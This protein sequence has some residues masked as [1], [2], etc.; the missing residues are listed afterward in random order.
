MAGYKQRCEV[1]GVATPEVAV[2]DNCCHVAT[3][4]SMHLPETPV[5]LDVYHF[6][7]RYAGRNIL[8]WMIS[9]LIWPGRYLAAVLNG[10]KNPHRSAIAAD[11]RNSILKSPAQGG[12]PAAYWS[13]QEQE[14]RL[15]ETFTK[16]M[17]KGQCWSAAAIKVSQICS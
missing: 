1:L 5:R 4:V 9:L 17:R 14:R 16:W 7:Q 2:T 12:K 13:Q 6:M 10:M 11:V 3:T 8:C 15:E